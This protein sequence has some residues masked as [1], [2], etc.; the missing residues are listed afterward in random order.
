MVSWL[1]Y[2]YFHLKNFAI[3]CKSQN[4][5]WSHIKDLYERES[6]AG[7]RLVPKL[8]YKHINITSFSA[9]RVDIAAQ[10]SKHLCVG[11]WFHV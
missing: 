4:I 11:N 10:V 5:W 2:T 9:M 8:K 7:I 6:S 3:K 1:L